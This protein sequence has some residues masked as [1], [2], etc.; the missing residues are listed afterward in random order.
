[1]MVFLFAG[2]SLLCS[3]IA[4]TIVITAWRNQGKLPLSS[5][6]QEEHYQELDERTTAVATKPQPVITTVTQPSEST[7]LKQPAV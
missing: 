5:S 7:L 2:V 4:T 1:M 3:L 6:K